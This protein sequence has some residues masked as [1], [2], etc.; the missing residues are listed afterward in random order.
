MISKVKERSAEVKFTAP[1]WWTAMPTIAATGLERATRSSMAS[2]AAAVGLIT[3]YSQLANIS[4]YI[5]CASSYNWAFWNATGISHLTYMGPAP[6]Q[7]SGVEAPITTYRTS[8]NLW[9]T[10]S[11]VTEVFEPWIRFLCLHWV[12]ILFGSPKNQRVQAQQTNQSTGLW[13]YCRKNLTSFKI[14]F[15]LFVYLSLWNP[16]F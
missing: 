2:S 16:F 6:P 7:Y 15:V 12:K 4:L 13:L 9:I 1:S 11:Q 5:R 3:C 14:C 8:R 10:T